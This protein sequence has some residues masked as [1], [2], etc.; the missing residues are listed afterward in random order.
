MLEGTNSVIS[1]VK[2][3]ARIFRNMNH[4]RDMIYLQSAGLNLPYIKLG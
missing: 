4:F 1:L 3:R 2:R